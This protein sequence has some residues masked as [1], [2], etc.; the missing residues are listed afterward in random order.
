MK[1]IFEKKI[2]LLYFLLIIAVCFSFV[3]T[4]ISYDAEY[5]LAM[6]YRLIKGDQLI[7]QMWE[8]HQT[9]SFL[10][11]ILMKA[12]MLIVGSTTGIVL[13]MQI[14]GL[15]IRGGIAI[16]LYKEINMISSSF[17]AMMASVTYLL[18]S[19][20]ELL[21]PEFGNMQLWCGT[22]LFLSL[23]RYFKTQKVVNLILGA[24]FLCF[25]VF[26]YPSF[27]IVYIAVVVLLLRYSQNGKYAI[28]VFTGVCALIGGCFVAYILLSVDLPT[29]MSVLD[30][31]LALEPTHTVNAFDKTLAHVLN[32]GMILGT[33]AVIGVIG[34]LVDGVYRY[35]YAKKKGKKIGW[36]QD[37]WL[38]ISW[39]ILMGFFLLNILSVRNRGG[40]AFPFV[41]I[42]M[43]GF[44]KRH[45]LSENEKRM[46]YSALLIS[47]VSLLAT[48]ILS[49]NAFLQGITYML[50]VICVS[51]V[52]IYYWFKELSGQGCL[53]KLFVGGMHI[54]CLLI[55]FRCIYIHIPLSE[56]DQIY[57]ILSDVALVRSGPAMGIIAEEAG[58]AKQRDS[59][60]EWKEYVEPGDVIWI[61][62]EPVD[63]L[64]YLY[65]DVE[66]G[67]PTVM[68]TP[69]YNEQIEY[70]WELNPQ[71][72]PD[73]VILASSFGELA[74][75]I[76]FNEWLHRWLE[77]EYKAD[78]IIDG[79]YWRY[80]I[81]H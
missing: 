39:L 72:F 21:L 63:T 24:A 26:S 7:L 25:G 18:I 52:P 13:Y 62:G 38:L 44:A 34:F 80:Y 5:Q 31:A 78:E 81:K 55:I 56:R 16:L 68:S 8:P 67:T 23:L 50:I 4:N 70:Y 77:E 69:T 6:A 36:S 43:V 33:L 2:Y 59:M 29:I 11:A 19:P 60:K 64:G 79:N 20:K 37:R 46:Y 75:E 49:D 10:P 9:S 1:K 17:P 12:Y 74:W 73:V 58:V 71:K 3:F 35:I 51:M 15:L 48:L 30:R 53:R 47:A 28:L 27:I 57:T 66:V 61:I 32:V 65:E 54:F 76:R 41:V 42:L 22:L 40:Y 45:L 14:V